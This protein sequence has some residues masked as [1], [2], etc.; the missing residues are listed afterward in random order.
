MSIIRR[1][2]VSG[3][4][5]NNKMRM[6]LRERERI[7]KRI[8]GVTGQRDGDIV[9]HPPRDGKGPAVNEQSSQ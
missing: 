1:T 4:A 9:C 5:G 7:V 2:L 6:F 8:A 3:R